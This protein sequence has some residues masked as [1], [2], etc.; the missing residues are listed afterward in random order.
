[1]RSGLYLVVCSVVASAK[2]AEVVFWVVVSLAAVVVV[3]LLVFRLLMPFIPRGQAGVYQINA[4][5]DDDHDYQYGQGVLGYSYRLTKR[6]FY[7]LILRF[8]E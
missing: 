3:S 5:A 8:E 6:L 2:A 7:P 1:M 4:H